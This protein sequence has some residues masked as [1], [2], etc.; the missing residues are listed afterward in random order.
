MQWVGLLQVT[1]W[2]AVS[3]DLKLALDRQHLAGL[4]SFGE[5]SFGPLFAFCSFVRF[6][7]HVFGGLPFLFKYRALVVF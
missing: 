7:L 1:G 6:R 2:C 4:I 5:L 3:G